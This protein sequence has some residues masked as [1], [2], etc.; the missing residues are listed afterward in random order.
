MLWDWGMRGEQEVS[1][2]E[3]AEWTVWWFEGLIW[4]LEVRRSHGH[5]FFS[6]DIEGVELSVGR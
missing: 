5:V 3:F 6:T 4:Y 2:R 1:S